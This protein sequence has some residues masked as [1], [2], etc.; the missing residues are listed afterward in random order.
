MIYHFKKVHPAVSGT[1][2]ESTQPTTTSV[3]ARK[4]I[5]AQKADAITKQATMIAN[6]MLPISVIKGGGF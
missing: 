5:G 3:L 6:D 1:G 4:K 2:F